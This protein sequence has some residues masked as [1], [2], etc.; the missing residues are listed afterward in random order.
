MCVFATFYGIFNVAKPLSD[1]R[2]SFL[3]LCDME[4]KVGSYSRKAMA[5]F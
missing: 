3:V 1:M 2:I 5:K 4:L